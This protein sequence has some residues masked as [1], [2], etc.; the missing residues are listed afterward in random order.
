MWEVAARSEVAKAEGRYHSA[1]YFDCSKC[2]ERVRHD[3]AITDALD[4]GCGPVAFALRFAMYG[5]KRS[6]SAH[7]AIAMGVT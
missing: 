1:A 6:I 4:T 5:Q 2:Y 7:G 3:V